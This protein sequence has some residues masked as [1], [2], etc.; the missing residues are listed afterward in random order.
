MGGGGQSGKQ[1]TTNEIAPELKPLYGQTGDIITGLQPQIADQ[2][3]NFF[4]SNPQ[5]IPSWTPNQQSLAD[6]QMG[7]AYGNPLSPYEQ[8]AANMASG[9]GNPN[10]TQQAALSQINQLQNTPFGT[11]P[12]T[13]SAIAAARDPALN[14][15]AQAGLGNSSAVGSA[16]A[17]AYAPIYAQE[18]AFRNQAV[19]QLASIGAQLQQGQQT[20]AGLLGQIGGTGA[21]RQTGLINTAMGTQEQA[22]ALQESQAAA[23]YQ[24]FMRQQ[25]LG[26][27]FTTGILGGFSPSIQLGSATTKSTSSGGGGK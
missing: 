13:L 25:G 1:T 17:G 18:M 2:F 26:S 20:G 7:R 16:L 6:T 15:L 12:T 11:L 8:Q 4:G 27:Q 14:E 23:N 22:R 9:F 24:D 5:Q 19:P 21:E 10:A 3:T